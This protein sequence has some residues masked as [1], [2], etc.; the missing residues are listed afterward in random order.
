MP[1]PAPCTEQQLGAAWAPEP[2]A[3]RSH[4]Q[5]VVFKVSGVSARHLARVQAAQRVRLA[6]LGTDGLVQ[7]GGHAERGRGALARAG[8]VLQRVQRVVVLH[9]LRQAPLRLCRPGLH[10]GKAIIYILDEYK[11]YNVLSSYR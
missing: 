2:R 7:A 3:R 10:V 1:G 9:H 4:G 5:G 8:D 11:V 6:V